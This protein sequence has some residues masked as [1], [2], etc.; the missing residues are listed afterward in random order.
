MAKATM[1]AVSL[2]SIWKIEIKPLDSTKINITVDILYSI[3]KK[4]GN[5]GC[6]FQLENSLISHSFF[7]PLSAI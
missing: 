2:G 7:L 1:P 3:K 6:Q 5:L 4:K